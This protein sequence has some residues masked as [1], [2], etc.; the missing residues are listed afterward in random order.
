MRK[1]FIVIERRSDYS[2]FRPILFKLKSDP[3]FKVYLVATG[4]TLIDRHGRG[5]NFIKKDGIKVDK[6]I[7][8]YDDIDIDSPAEMIRGMSRF[9]IKIV[10]ELERVKPDLVLSGF[11]IGAQLA[12]TIAAAHLNIPIAH[13][14]GGELSGSIDESIRHAMSKFSHI[15]LTATKISKQRLIKMGEHP[16]NIYVVGCPSV[17]TLVKCKK[18]KKEVIEKKFGVD[19]S[20]PVAILI[21]HPVTTEN[22]H[23]YSQIK[24][25]IQAI[26]SLNLQVVAI[27]PNNDAGYSKIFK[28]INYS[29]IKAY[30]N[31]SGEEYSNLLR[32]SDILIGNS[33]SGI[34]EAATFKIPVINIGTRQRGRERTRNV[35]DVPHDK[36]LIIK[37]IKKALYDKSFKK[38]LKKIKN[39]YGIGNST[40]KIIKILKKISLK[41]LIQK[42]F[43]E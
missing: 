34:H 24:T 23:S 13:L 12:V 2:R 10:D 25:T 20:K 30:P 17:D 8:M 28:K 11:D 4:L 35:I 16:K 29:K 39:I 19:F 37:A 32:Y 42:I 36:Y 41:G 27:M 22:G 33:S 6:E 15:H 1:I 5:I 26:K 40:D 14:Q 7:P 38:K 3:F 9:M 21:Q 31:L 43:Y 18:I